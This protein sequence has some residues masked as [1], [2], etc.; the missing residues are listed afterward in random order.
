MMTLEIVEADGYVGDG[1]DIVIVVHANCLLKR[2]QW[3]YC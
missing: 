3:Q 1:D 2:G